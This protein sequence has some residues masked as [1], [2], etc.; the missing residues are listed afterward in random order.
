[1]KAIIFDADGVLIGGKD[2][3]GRYLWHKNIGED[4]GLSS[5]QVRQIFSGD[6]SLVLKGFLDS[7]QHFESIFAKLNIGLSVD[8]FVEYWLKN[9]STVN[10]EILPIIESIKGIKLYIGTN[11]DRCRTKILQKKFGPYFDSIFSSYQIGAIKPDL[12]F[13]RYIES[14]LN[15]QSKDIAFI[16]DSISHIEAAARVGWTCHH[17]QNI[18]G[19]KNFIRLSI[20]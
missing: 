12:K 6:W 1:M 20:F 19:F 5:D 10:T 18:E 15:L 11:Q 3:T 4:L 17:Y 16:D 2:K 13:Y 7:R 14:N 8:D 9:D